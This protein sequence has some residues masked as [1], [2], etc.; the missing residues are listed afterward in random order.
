M[1]EGSMGNFLPHDLIQPGRD[2]PILLPP[3]EWFT[4]PYVLDERNV[5]MEQSS[6]GVELL[7]VRIVSAQLRWWSVDLDW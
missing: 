5:R 1:W 7:V 2:F 4:R 3:R 6:E